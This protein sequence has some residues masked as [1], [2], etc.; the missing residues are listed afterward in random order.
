MNLAMLGYGSIAREHVQAIRTLQNVPAGSD[1]ELHA[2]M[3]RLLEPT[4]EFA[5][6]LG[7][8]RATTDIG[9][10]LADPEVDAVIICSPTDLHAEQT[11]RALHAGKHVLCEIPLATSLADTDQAIQLAD[12]RDLRLMVCHTERYFPAL[13]EA[14]RMVKMGELHPHAIISRYMFHRRSNV[15]WVGRQRSWTDNLLWHHG[16]HAVDAA[17]WLLG[18]TEVEVS[19]QVALPGG[20]LD[21]PMDLSILMRTPRDQLVTVSMSYNTHIPLHDYLVIGEE[22]T[23]L[24]EIP[25]SSGSSGVGQLR[26]DEKVLVQPQKHSG[27]D[28]PIARQD[29]EFF[30]A[31]RD[32]REPAISARAVR[33]AMGAL[34][35]AQDSLDARRRALGAQARHPRLP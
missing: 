14:Q 29:A 31:V 7:F 20:Q 25:V 5:Q 10:V 18:A 21:I 3:G 34:Q 8:S 13:A 4:K 15:N 11:Q 17:L 27:V 12:E 16:C 28:H 2:V 30:A 6:E 26:N 24:F 9:E 19:A 23:V 1:V 35:A 22:T 32:R 33:P